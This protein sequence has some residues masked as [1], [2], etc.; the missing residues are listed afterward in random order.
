MQQAK[1]TKDDIRLVT[2]FFLM[3][4]QAI[5]RERGTFFLAGQQNLHDLVA[6]AWGYGVGA[7]WRRVVLGIDVLIDECCDPNLD[8]LEWRP[9]VRN[10]LK[11][12]G[13]ENVSS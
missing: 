3:L 8:H 7:S 9:D 5:E 10:F 1:A 11:N 2:D 6:D 12:Q 13:G 4:E